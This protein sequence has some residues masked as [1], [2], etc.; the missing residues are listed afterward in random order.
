MLESAKLKAAKSPIDSFFEQLTLLLGG[1]NCRLPRHGQ[2]RDTAGRPSRLK[3]ESS[4]DA[5]DIQAFARE[6]EVGDY[7]AFHPAEVDFL[8]SN[9][10]AGYEF[11]L[12]RGLALNFESSG[13]EFV[14]Q[15][16]L[17]LLR[18]VRPLGVVV[19]VGCVQDSLPQ[20]SRNLLEYFAFDQ[21]FTIPFSQVGETLAHLFF[22]LVAQP[23]DG[24]VEAVVSLLQSAGLPCRETK[25]CRA[26]QSAMGD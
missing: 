20:A 26:A 5:V 22:G 15:C 13:N 10:T 18:Q 19:Y 8:E 4:C 17:G 24:N 11:F 23:V 25:D 2:A 21:G 9:A 16:R 14:R 6:K 12:V 1:L 3:V 7:S